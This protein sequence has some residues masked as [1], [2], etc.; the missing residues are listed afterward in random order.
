MIL[1]LAWMSRVECIDPQMVAN[2]STRYPPGQ[3]SW[4]PDITMNMKLHMY[5]QVHFSHVDFFEGHWM[6]EMI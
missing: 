4:T 2:F 5:V 3:L 1:Q 6:R